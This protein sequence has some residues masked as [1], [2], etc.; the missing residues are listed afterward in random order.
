MSGTIDGDELR[1]T[2]TFTGPLVV[3]PAVEELNIQVQIDDRQGCIISSSSTQRG[4]VLLFSGSQF[5]PE[6]ELTQLDVPVEVDP[7]ATG[8]TVTFP[9]P[10]GF[11]PLDGIVNLTA[12]WFGTNGEQFFDPIEVSAG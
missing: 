12:F 1:A 8:W 4:S 10:D 11:V 5:S 2:I 3:D 9:L 7:A 6:G